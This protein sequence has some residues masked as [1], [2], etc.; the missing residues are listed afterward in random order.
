MENIMKRPALHL[1]LTYCRMQQ[2]KLTSHFSS[3]LTLSDDLDTWWSSTWLNVIKQYSLLRFVLVTWCQLKSVP[4]KPNNL[5]NQI[6]QKVSH[7]NFLY[8]WIDQN[9]LCLQ[10]VISNPA[11]ALSNAVELTVSQN[12][13]KGAQYIKT[14]D[15]CLNVYVQSGAKITWYQR[16]H[17]KHQIWSGFCATLYSLFIGTWYYCLCFL[18]LNF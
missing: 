3:C 17:I 16:Q 6:C 13:T 12:S 4:I 7:A 9:T 18:L 1:S 15:E 5:E 8:Y 14:N 2:F 10:I 11:T